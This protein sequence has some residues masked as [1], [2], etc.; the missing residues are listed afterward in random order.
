MNDL[1]DIYSEMS[2]DC[3]YAYSFGAMSAYFSHIDD[4]LSENCP[5]SEKTERIQAIL[6]RANAIIGAMNRAKAD[7]MTKERDAHAACDGWDQGFNE[8]RGFVNVDTF[9]D[10]P[11][12][13]GWIAM[14]EGD[15]NN[16][17]FR[18]RM[19]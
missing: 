6:G 15:A 14:N 3:C 8:R 4:I 16:D 12:A 5:P 13:V 17:L 2:T 11:D 19:I 18:R 10:L 9:K 7:R 1:N